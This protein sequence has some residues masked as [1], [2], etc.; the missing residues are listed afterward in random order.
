M[1][2][3]LIG[4]WKMQI[5]P[6]ESAALASAIAREWNGEGVTSS[7]TVV[8][9]PSHHAVAGVADA[10]RGMPVELGA[11]DAFWEDKGAFTGEVSAKSLAAF[12]CRYCIV[13]HSERR[14][15]LGETDAMARRKVEAI[16]R[17]GMHPVVCVGETDEEK[18][19]GKAAAVVIGQLRSA[20][21][22]IR[23]VGNQRIL[24]AY[25]PRW[26][27]GTG[28]PAMPADAAEMHQLIRETLFEML[29]ADIVN[30]QCAVLYGGSVDSGNIADFLAEEVI[31]GVLAGGA[32]LKAD[33]FVRMARIAADA[34]R[35]IE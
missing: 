30:S 28:R 21:A 23:P 12:G 9:C 1:S 31:S 26:A 32:S 5:E 20:L 10:L 6:A 27:I 17:H 19:S 35:R 3:F 7:V 15:H 24:V 29:P 4:N 13:G 8:V 33:E 16:M 25:E 34:K 14:L 22:E 18:R 2:T 11:Q